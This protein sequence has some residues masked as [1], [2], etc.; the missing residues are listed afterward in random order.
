VARIGVRELNQQ[1]SRILERVRAGEVVEITDRGRPVARLIPVRDLPQPLDRLVA[2]GRANPPDFSGPIPEPM[3]LG[4]PNLDVA[5][6][7]AAMRDED[8]RPTP[9]GDLDHLS[10]SNS[11]ENA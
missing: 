4:D 9:I 5:S 8:D 10:R 3:S 6:A 1:T 11:L 7:L 2:E